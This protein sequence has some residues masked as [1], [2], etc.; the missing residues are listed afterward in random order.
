MSRGP[1]IAMAS[2]DALDNFDINATIVP[3]VALSATLS[4][5]HVFV[6]AA[7]NGEVRAPS[8]AT[9]ALSSSLL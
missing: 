5:L 8:P 7:R 3:K 9:K 6:A 1:I 2:V 4:T